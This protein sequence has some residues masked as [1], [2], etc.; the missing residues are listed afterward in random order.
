[1]TYVRLKPSGATTPF[2]ICNRAV[3][4]I[5]AKTLP[6]MTG[7]STKS[8]RKHTIAVRRIRCEDE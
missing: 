5:A 4:P 3:G 6:D 1:M 7:K 2:P 8:E